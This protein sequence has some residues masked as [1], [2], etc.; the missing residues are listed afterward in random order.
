MINYIRACRRLPLLAGG[1]RKE[2]G[3][4]HRLTSGDALPLLGPLHEKSAV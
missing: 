1:K 3:A 2:S 4:S